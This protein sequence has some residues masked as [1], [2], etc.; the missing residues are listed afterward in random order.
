MR[1]MDKA[2]RRFFATL[3]LLGV[4]IVS[5]PVPTAL[6]SE[7]VDR[8]WSC[9]G[10]MSMSYVG[11][12]YAPNEILGG[13]V[14]KEDE[15]TFQIEHVHLKIAGDLSRKLSFVLTPCLTHMERFSVIEAKFTYKFADSFLLTAGRFLVPFGQF[16]ERSMPGSFTPVSRPLL[17]QSHES[18][19]ITF[20]EYSP[21]YFLF[22]PREDIGI[23]VSG[24]L[25]LG[26]EDT[27]QV[28]YGG[29]VINGFRADS[30][31]MVRHWDDNN[32]YKG[33][34]GRLVYSIYLDRWELSLGSS[35]LWTRYEEDLDQTAYSLEA[36]IRTSLLDRYQTTL[37]GE[38]VVSPREMIPDEEMLQGDKKT[39]GFYLTLES[40]LAN[41]LTVYGQYDLLSNEYVRPLLNEGFQR[42]CISTNRILG[43]AVISPDR[44]IEVKFEYGYW[45]H[46]LALPNAHRIALQAILAF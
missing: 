12:M 27:V 39:K 9:F 35:A 14:V 7:K 33:F 21:E 25:W 41:W 22:T 15:H 17:Y 19:F 29:Y 34:G 1:Y 44:I 13:L 24:S 38:F 8:S 11:T 6:A 46:E 30:N 45:M 16:N 28:W 43:G 42:E 5:C 32:N 2:L 4:L 3:L 10:V 26:E 37:R 23:Q 18:R 36:L 20:D 40:R 31:T